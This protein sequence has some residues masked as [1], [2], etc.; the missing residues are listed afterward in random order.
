MG[1]E[2]ETAAV[3]PSTAEQLENKRASTANVSRTVSKR[4][5]YGSSE[6][7]AS[8]GGAKDLSQDWPIAIGVRCNRNWIICKILMDGCP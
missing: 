1:A 5:D 7:H 6:P 3:G 2:S 4:K 8:L